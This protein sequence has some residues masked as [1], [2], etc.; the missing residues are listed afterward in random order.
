MTACLPLLDCIVQT[1]SLPAVGRKFLPPRCS[2]ANKATGRS[3][4]RLILRLYMGAARLLWPRLKLHVCPLLPCCSDSFSNCIQVLCSHLQ[5]QDTKLHACMHARARAVALLTW[6]LY[7][8]ACPA[9][10]SGYQTAKIE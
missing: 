7:Q 3:D 2:P 6:F 4:G 8:T 5:W 10:V 9:G 1:T